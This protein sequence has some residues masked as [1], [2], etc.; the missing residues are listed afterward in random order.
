MM[1]TATEKMLSKMIDVNSPIIFIND[2]DFVRVDDLIVK[3]V[4]EK[5]PIVEWNPG[6]STTNFKNKETS[7]SSENQSLGDFLSEKYYELFG[8]EQY[9]VL[10]EILSQ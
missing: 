9:L 4:G 2:Y 8:G 6:T 7:G 3:T 5:T 10:K 1:A